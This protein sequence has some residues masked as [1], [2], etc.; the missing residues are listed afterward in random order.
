MQNTE[1][2]TV[3]WGR[4]SSGRTWLCPMSPIDLEC[5]CLTFMGRDLLTMESGHLQLLSTT[6]LRIHHTRANLQ[7]KEEMFSKEVIDTTSS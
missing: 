3:Y 7:N 5:I 4:S 1:L 6:H 2:P